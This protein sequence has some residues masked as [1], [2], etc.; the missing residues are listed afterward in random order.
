MANSVC[1]VGPGSSAGQWFSGPNVVEKKLRDADYVICAPDRKQ[2]SKADWSKEGQSSSNEVSCAAAVSVVFTHP[3]DGG[4]TKENAPAL[5][6]R[7]QNSD[8]LANL[9]IHVS[10]RPDS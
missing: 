1:R 9:E 8:V 5:S 4:L 3:V 10:C 2:K 7:L 6:V